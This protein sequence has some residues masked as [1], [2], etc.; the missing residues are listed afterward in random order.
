MLGG[1]GEELDAHEMTGHITLDR[2]LG[3]GQIAT[4]AGLLLNAAVVGLGGFY[5]LGVVKGQLDGAINLLATK[6]DSATTEIAGV[7]LEIKSVR[8]DVAQNVRDLQAQISNSK[9]ATDQRI[10]TLMRE[11]YAEEGRPHR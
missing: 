1:V 8:A 9:A 6:L 10:D 3:V 11:R 2:K 7:K 4:V 5:A